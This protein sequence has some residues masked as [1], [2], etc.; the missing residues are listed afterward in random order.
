MAENRNSPDLLRAVLVLVATIGTISFNALAAMGYING[1]TPETVSSKYPTVLT[2]A[3][4]AFSIWSLIYFGLVV[5]SIY[6]LLPANRER[7]RDI[8]SIY[9]VSC[10]LNCGWIYFWHNDRI[11]VCL[12][13]IVLL[14]ATLAYLCLKVKATQTPGELWGV[15]APFGLYAGWVTTASLV[16]FMVMLSYLGVDMPTGTANMIGIV[17]IAAAAVFAVLGRV[18]LTN[19]IFPLAVAWGLAAIAIKQSGNTP[20]VV[21]AVIGVV[22]G[23]ITAMTF[24]VNLPDSESRLRA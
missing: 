17:C 23:L 8:R 11:A 4:Y 9:I 21:A 5:F 16:N 15:K 6:Q 12:G 18:F 3:G 10:V 13:L 1:V 7:Y 22:V 2:P 20:I 24:V 19:Y 14:A